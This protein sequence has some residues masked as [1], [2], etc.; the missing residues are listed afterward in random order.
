MIAHELGLWRSSVLQQPRDKHGR[1][2]HV[3]NTPFRRM[4]RVTCNRIARE[5]GQ[6]E[7]FA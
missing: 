2:I 1:F 6:P 3:E 5:I 7:P 4:V